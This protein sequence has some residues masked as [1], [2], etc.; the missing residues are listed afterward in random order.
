MRRY[1]LSVEELSMNIFAITNN[2]LVQRAFEEDREQFCPD[3]KY[4]ECSAEALLIAVRDKVH[5]GYSLISHPLAASIRM[6]Y[7][8]YRTVILGAKEE[9][10]DIH[11]IEVIESSIIKHRQITEHRISDDANSEAYQWIDLQLLYAALKE[12]LPF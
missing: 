11:H 2:P 6:I 12:P 5:S 3:V 10:P 8:P 9:K 7:S 4:L 1:D